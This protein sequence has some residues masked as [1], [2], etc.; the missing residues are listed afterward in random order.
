MPKQIVNTLKNLLSPQ[1]RAFVR[2]I[3]YRWVNWR[4]AIKYPAITPLHKAVFEKPALRFR[5]EFYQAAQ[6]FLR[7]N[8]INGSYL[9]FGSHEANTFRMALNTLGMHGQPNRITHFLAFDSFEGMPEPTGIDRQKIWRAAMNATGEETFKKITRKDI[10]RVTTVK[11]FYKHSLLKI[12]LPDDQYPALAYLD[13]DYYTSTREV[14]NWLGKYLRHGYILA[15][16]DWDCYFADNSRG[17]RKA[18][19]EF[20]AKKMMGRLCSLLS[21]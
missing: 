7:V 12:N 15:F 19:L 6:I 16:D 1:Q 3:Y 5:L 20:K 11:G 14:L 18:F 4:D 13:C 21:S 8:R 17:Q 2:P 9:E 10:Y